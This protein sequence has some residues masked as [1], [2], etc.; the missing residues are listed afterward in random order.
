MSRT[1]KGG[2]AVGYEYWGKRP[3]SNEHG[4]PPGKETKKE[5]HKIERRVVDKEAIKEQLK[6]E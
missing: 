1:K 6:D 2:R 3:L 4:A 5:T